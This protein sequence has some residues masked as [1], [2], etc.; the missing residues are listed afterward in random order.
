MSLDILIAEDE[1]ITALQLEDQLLEDGLNVLGIVDTAER[2][3]NFVQKQPPHLVLLDIRLKGEMD[4]IEAARIFNNL[5]IPVIFLSAYADKDTRA[6]MA[7]INYYAFINKPFDIDEIR[8]V[9]SNFKEEL[10]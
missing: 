2:A 10:E 6:R 3:V 9:I 8:S 5:K 1:F 7:E 4:G